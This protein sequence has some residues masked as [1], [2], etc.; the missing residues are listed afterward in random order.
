MRALHVLSAKIA[1]EQGQLELA[2]KELVEAASLD[3]K[4]A[5]ANYL[6]ALSISVGRSPM[7]R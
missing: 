2:E 7:K 4:N 6:R 3:A 5:E 1:I